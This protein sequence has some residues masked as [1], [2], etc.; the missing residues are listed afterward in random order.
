MFGLAVPIQICLGLTRDAVAM[1]R[2]VL[3]SEHFDTAIVLWGAGLGT[4]LGINQP[5]DIVRAI[6]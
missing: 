5:S 6:I 2:A 3:A 1:G 4:N